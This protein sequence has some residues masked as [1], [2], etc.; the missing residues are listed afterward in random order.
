M[1]QLVGEHGEKAWDILWEIARGDRAGKAWFGSKFG[2]IEVDVRP[3]LREQM[4]ASLAIIEHLVGRPAVTI[5]G[6]ADGEPV[7]VAM[8][9]EPPD[10]G[11]LAAILR[12]LGATG[13]IALGEPASGPGQGAGAEADGILGAL[14]NA[15]PA[16]IPSP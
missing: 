11:E 4:D 9:H 14:A 13:S 6:D 7:K 5:A 16:G 10:P 3:S 15:D 12:V 2:P 1:R 8:K